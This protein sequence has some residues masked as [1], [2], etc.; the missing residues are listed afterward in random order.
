MSEIVRRLR[1]LPGR[2]TVGVA[3][4]LAWLTLGS[5]F[6]ALKIGVTSAP[7][8]LFS[9]TRFLVVGAILL[10][11]VGWRSRG[12]FD[13]ERRELMIAAAIGV[14]FILVGQGSVTW[15]SQYLASGVI[16]VP[17]SAMPLW[18]ALIGRVAWGVRIASA[19]QLGLVAG[20]AGVV[21]LAWPARGTGVSVGP[22]LLVVGGSAAWARS[23]PMTEKASGW[24]RIQDLMPLPPEC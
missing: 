20:F 6:V 17:T 4:P 1:R 10:A 12:H 22:A 9:G 23:T 8:F 21:L 7:P 15:S 19:G 16:A 5:V 18:A 13:L 11:W 3:L 2:A 14:A 24:S